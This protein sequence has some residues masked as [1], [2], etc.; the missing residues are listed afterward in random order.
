MRIKDK[1]RSREWVARS[2]HHAKPLTP[3]A[4]IAAVI[5]NKKIVGMR[6]TTRGFHIKTT[7]G[8]YVFAPVQGYKGIQI[9]KAGKCL[10]SLMVAS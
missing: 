4:K 9:R 5:V 3:L 2:L 1:H 7:K 8:T 10:I 6:F